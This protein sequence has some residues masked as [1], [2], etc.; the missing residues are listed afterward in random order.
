MLQLLNTTAN[1]HLCTETDEN[2][3]TLKYCIFVNYMLSNI[4]K[5]AGNPPA[6]ETSVA[7]KTYRLVQVVILSTGARMTRSGQQPA[8]SLFSFA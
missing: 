2:I 3:K 8:F 6:H 5:P 7:T 1:G 4:N